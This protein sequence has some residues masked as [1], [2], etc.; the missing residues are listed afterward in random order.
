MTKLKLIAVTQRYIHVDGT[1]EDR[2]SLDR[3]WYGFLEKAGLLP[4]IL[5]NDVT[6]S[7]ALLK[8]VEI[9]GILL[10]GGGNIAALG[11]EDTDRDDVERFLIEK[12]IKEEISLLGVCRG[13]QK[14]Q[15]YFGVPFKRVAGHVM[16]VQDIMVNGQMCPVNSYHDFGATETVDVLSVWAKSSD[17]V[18]KAVRHETYP[19]EGIMWHPERIEPFRD[20]DIKYFQTFYARGKQ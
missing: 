9:E 8:R 7:E 19:I 15:S 10:S 12:S 14:I 5:P 4:L 6:L 11:G 1:K 2:D 18:I 13:M 3:R 17:N 20:E 16:P